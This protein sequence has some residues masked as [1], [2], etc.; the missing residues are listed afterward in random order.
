MAEVKAVLPK[1]VYFIHVLSLFFHHALAEHCAATFFF[2]LQSRLL[3]FCSVVMTE[4]HKRFL[5]F[6]CL[7]LV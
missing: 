1:W 3:R 4:I 6:F 5:G 7:C 2:M